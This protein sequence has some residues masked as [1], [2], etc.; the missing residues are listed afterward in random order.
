MADQLRSLLEHPTRFHF[1]TGKGG[2][3]KTSLA[4]ATA[5][6]LADRG[7]RTLLVSTDPASNLDAVLD[8]TLGNT[9]LPVPGVPHLLAMNVDPD[10]AAR[11]YRERTVAPYRGT[12][13][14][15]ELAQLQEQL[16][17][18]CTVEV[19]AFDEFTVL[20]GQ[21]ELMQSIEHV[22]FDTAPTGHTLRLLQLPAAWSRYL[23]TSN[24]DV[25]CLGPL[26]GLK[27]QQARYQEAVR[28]L[29]DAR[30]TTLVIVARPDRVALLEADRTRQELGA[31]GMQNQMLIVNAVFHATDRDDPV[32]LAVEDRADRALADMTVGL[33][34]LRRI[35]VP[36]RG[37]NIVGLPKVRAFLSEPQ[38]EEL[39]LPHQE[40]TS[41]EA[42][43]MPPL[44]SIIDE[45]ATS[46][47]GLVMV[48][49]KGGVGKTTIA[50]SI[51]VALA[52]R[53][54]PVLLTTTDPASHLTETVAA[55]IP[56]LSVSRIDPMAEARRYREETYA[57]RAAKL[58]AE[59][60]ALLQE[61]LQSPCYD[62]IA[63]FVAFSKIVVRAKREL[64]VVDTAPTGHTLRLLDTAGAYHRQLVPHEPKSG[65]PRFVTP[66]MIMRDPDVTRVL[67]VTLAE[68]TPVLEAQV[69]QEDLR[70]AGIEPFAWVVNASLLAAQ[71]TD[72]VLQQ[73]AQAEVPLINRVAADLTHRVALVP[74][75]VSEPSGPER[76][77]QVAGASQSSRPARRAGA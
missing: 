74:F 47:H 49:G 9:P 44:A 17:G 36:M 5:V 4:C 41:G 62:E 57:T 67:I 40:A 34:A 61:E 7:Q 31:L 25:S 65:E 43:A 42:P 56:R 16:A 33:R 29:G 63:F 30:A 76:L 54:R 69:L 1:F 60:R 15:A 55:A 52:D 12:V 77:R 53:G 37:F 11:D 68:T 66:L 45:L 2:V 39:R 24:P 6:G 75:Q 72:P 71:V 27:A 64:V 13:P 21:N 10:A 22:V 20:L 51:A 46:D 26:A 18:A 23:D 73:R 59:Q 48:M 50:A 19:A 38:D 32:A 70:K 28:T 3:G 35:D 14:E 8:V 58:D